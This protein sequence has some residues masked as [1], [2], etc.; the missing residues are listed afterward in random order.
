MSMQDENSYFAFNYPCTT[1]GGR[2]FLAD[3]NIA[4]T[5]LMNTSTTVSGNQLVVNKEY[6]R[7]G[8]AGDWNNFRGTLGIRR[9][10]G[11]WQAWFLKMEG[12]IVT[13]EFWS[14]HQKMSYAP[15]GKLSYLTLYIGSHDNKPSDMSLQRLVVKNLTPQNPEEVN[16]KKFQQGDVLKI[17]MY[18]NKVWLNDKPYNDIDIGSQFFSLE[19]G[20]N[21]IKI[22][23]DKGVHSNI[24]FNEKYL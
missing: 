20:E 13:K 4:P 23:S 12:G 15:T 16:I 21:V 7:S 22:S 24:I 2:K 10:N 8:R 6:I 9:E 11:Y 1:V 5:P 18:N 3:T 14:T 19:T 17:D